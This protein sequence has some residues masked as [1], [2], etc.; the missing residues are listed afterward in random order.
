M[1]NVIKETNWAGG[2][3]LMTHPVCAIEETEISTLACL[4]K[5]FKVKFSTF[6]SGNKAL[7]SNKTFSHHLH[8]FECI[9]NQ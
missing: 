4:Q 8:P 3:L 9:L 2:P 7:T 6:E 5:P 1:K